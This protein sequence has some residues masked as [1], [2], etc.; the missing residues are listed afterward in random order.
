LIVKID[1]L[2]LIEAVGGNGGKSG[3]RAK[4]NEMV[5]MPR[6]HIYLALCIRNRYTEINTV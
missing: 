5:L 6:T 4:A 2:K 3:R 1:K